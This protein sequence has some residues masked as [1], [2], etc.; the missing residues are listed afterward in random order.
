MSLEVKFREGEKVVSMVVHGGVIF[1]AT[2]LAVYVV[3]GDVMRPLKIEYA[4]EP[5]Q[6]RR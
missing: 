3:Y 1:V 6:K 5:Q 4:D 2:N